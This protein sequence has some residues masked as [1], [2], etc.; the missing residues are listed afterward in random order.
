MPIGV[1]CDAFAVALGGVI[2]AV[3]GN[4]MSD[5]FREKLNLIFGLCSMGI[6][7]SSIVLMKNMPAVV[8]AIILG[9]IIGVVTHLGQHIEKGGQKLAGLIPGK[10]ST[11][12]A[13]LVTAIVLFCASGTGI[14]GAIVS[15]MSGDHSILLA[16]SILHCLDLCLLAWH[17]DKPGGSCAAGDLPFA[18]CVRKADFPAD[19]P[20]HDFRFQGLRRADHARDRISHCQD[21]GFSHCRHDSRYGAGVADQL[22]L[23]SVDC[24]DAVRKKGVYDSGDIDHQ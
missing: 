12:N 10:G 18:L 20:G 9:T 6:G 16:K 23:D 7:I 3:A 4:R 19:D 2:G 13:L 21:E 11:D 1:L 17:G 14:Y 5:E 22:C 15:G 24:T 8:L